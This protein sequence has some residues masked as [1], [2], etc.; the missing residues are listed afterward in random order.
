[1]ETLIRDV[2]FAV[3]RLAKKPVFTTIAIASLAIGIGAN[4]AIFTLVNAVMLQ[5]PPIER[6]EEVVEVY[7]AT[8]GF[9]HATFSYPDLEDLGRVTDEV[10]SDVA[11]SRIS[12]VQTDTDGGVKVLPAELVTGN[13]FPMLGVPAL[14][15]RTLRPSDDVSPGAHPVVML[16][17]GYWQ[18]HFGG[19]PGVIGEAIRLNGRE[20]TIIGVVPRDWIGNLRG[21]TPEV[22]ASTMMMASLVTSDDSELESRGSASIFVK[23]RLRPGVSL[24][25]AQ[26]VL[27]RFAESQRRSYP[28]QWQA[29]NVISAVPTDEVIMNPMIDRILVPAAVMLVVVMFLVLT[30]ACANLGSFLLAQAMDRRKEVATRLALGATRATL[31]RQWLTE[32]LMLALLGGS[33]GLLLASGLLGALVNADLPL[34]IPITLDLSLN[35]NVLGFSLLISLATGIFF[36][37]APAVQATQLDLAGTLKDE[38]AGGGQAKKITL[39][40][41]LVVVQVAVSLVL[42][43]GA[44]LFL[45]SLQARLA[46][47]P[48]FGY[49]PAAILTVHASTD[50]YTQKEAHVFLRTLVQEASLLPGVES[51]GM[52]G[53]LPLSTLNNQILNVTVVGVDPPPGHDH[54]SIDWAEA[55]PG[56]FDAAGVTIVEGRSFDER[57]R[58]DSAAVAIISQAFAE[59]F[60]PGSEAVGR[61]FRTGDTEVTVVGVSRDAKI[62]SLGEAPRPF[63]FLPF[64]QSSSLG[65]TL[66]A[67]TAAPANGLLVNLVALARR[68]DP[69]LLIIESK[70]MERHLAVMLLPQ[71]LSAVVVGAFGALAL[72]LASIGLYGVVS[73]AASARS[74]EVGIRVALGADPS[75]VVRLLMGGG[76]KL[77]ALGGGVGLVLSVLFV[78]LLGGLIYGVGTF[79]PLAF[80]VVPLVLGAVALTAAWIPA[81]RA[82]RIDPVIALKGE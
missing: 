40:N 25:A 45:R 27:D 52:I 51:A 74:R 46:V 49:Q 65:M 10:F 53:D 6:S 12:F 13:F 54:H 11:G 70:T 16:G 28:D 43:V 36:G 17:Y 47:D 79:D 76:M 71:R 37:L 80:G 38:S 8:A 18:R 33:A 4:T 3:R 20:Y 58:H 1:M 59:R 22:Y 68:L 67:Q 69:E 60:W 50:R 44:G 81:R 2:R 64:E 63:V 19:D 23:A 15:G 61:T 62:R 26:G 55:D 82:G 30:I 73:Y 39:R 34:P 42:L 24:V 7:R 29:D 78:Q 57:D 66:V 31:I 48:G 32:T 9:S 14:V 35:G 77:V 21:M 72:L 75:I 5:E 56:F 41:A